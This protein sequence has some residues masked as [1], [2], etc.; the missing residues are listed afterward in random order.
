MCEKNCKDCKNKNGIIFICKS[1]YLLSW[2]GY[3]F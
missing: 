1:C 3:D 2:N